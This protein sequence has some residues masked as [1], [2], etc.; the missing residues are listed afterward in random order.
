MIPSTFR[1]GESAGRKKGAQSFGAARQEPP[2]CLH[3]SLEPVE[4]KRRS[5]SFFPQA[6]M[7]K[8]ISI[9]V[10][11]A[12]R[13][14]STVK[15]GRMTSHGLGFCPEVTRASEVRDRSCEFLG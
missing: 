11:E 8:R 2:F 10:L 1:H 3:A 5:L 15:G 12:D 13:T 4:K 9:D 6:I 14:L 7:E